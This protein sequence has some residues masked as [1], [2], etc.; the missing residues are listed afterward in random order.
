MRNLIVFGALCCLLG[1]AI[2]IGM[3]RDVLPSGEPAGDSTSRIPHIGRIQVLNGCGITGAAGAVSDFLRDRSFDVKNIGNADTW[4]YPF[5]MIVSRTAD[6][7]IA[8][9]VSEALST[10]KLILLRDG[11]DVYDVTVIL[12]P[13]F[14]GRIEE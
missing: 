10:D 6:M 9:R 2:L 4:N 14:D 11:G 3:R 13:D 1:M 8:R 12:G 5:T 7:T